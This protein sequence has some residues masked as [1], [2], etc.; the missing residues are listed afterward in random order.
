MQ[1]GIWISQWVLDFSHRNRRVVLTHRL[2]ALKGVIVKIRY[3][4]RE[5][6]GNGHFSDRTVGTHFLTAHFFSPLEY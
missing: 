4:A 6:S 2:I 5:E 3:D 1:Q